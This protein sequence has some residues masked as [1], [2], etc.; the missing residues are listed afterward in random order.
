MYK[1]TIHTRI[2]AVACTQENQK[3]KW[4]KKFNF[5]SIKLL[6]SILYFTYSQDIN[7]QGQKHIILVLLSVQNKQSFV[8]IQPT[9]WLWYKL[10]LHLSPFYTVN[11][12]IFSPVFTFKKKIYIFLFLISNTSYFFHKYLYNLANW[13]SVQLFLF[14][15]TRMWQ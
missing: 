10:T 12:T 5:D 11:D 15:Y 4:K 6:V 7:R 13:H 8:F 3:W 14:T 1:R 9:T 2:Y